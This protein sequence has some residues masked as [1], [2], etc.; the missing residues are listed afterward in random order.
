M[1]S[2]FPLKQLDTG[3]ASDLV[4]LDGGA[5][6]R[7]L[8]SV[9]RYPRLKEARVGHRAVSPGVGPLSGLITH[10]WP[11]APD[12]TPFRA[13]EAAAVPS[14][15]C[16]LIK[17]AGVTPAPPV[18]CVSCKMALALSNCA[19]A[20]C[21]AGREGRRTRNAADECGGRAGASAAVRSGGR[22][23]CVLAA[24]AGVT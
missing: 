4:R 12:V 9:R 6:C 13:T 1:R 2:E 3:G 20:A 11:P 18:P 24:R 19:L 17:Q 14:E 22:P 15:Q 7:R 21:A 10:S 5:R 8:C 16:Q 23:Y